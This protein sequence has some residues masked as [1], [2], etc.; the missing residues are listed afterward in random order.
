MT[1]ILQICQA[2]LASLP[3]YRMLLSGE[4][5]SSARALARGREYLVALLV[6]GMTVD[7]KDDEAEETKERRSTNRPDARNDDTQ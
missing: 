2:Y 6:H 1:L 4:D 3:L 5:V 7:L